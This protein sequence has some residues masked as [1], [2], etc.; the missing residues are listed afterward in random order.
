MHHNELSVKWGLKTWR[1]NIGYKSVAL[2]KSREMKKEE[3]RNVEGYNA[4]MLKAKL[5]FVS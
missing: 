4:T 3:E 2:R 5:N 1:L